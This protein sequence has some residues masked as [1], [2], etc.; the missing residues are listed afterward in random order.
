MN[1]Y[2]DSFIPVKEWFAPRQTDCVITSI[3]YDSD[4]FMRQNAEPNPFGSSDCLNVVEWLMIS[5]VPFL[6][7]GC[8]SLIFL[9]RFQSRT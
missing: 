9:L 1:A 3:T 6:A 8:G 2:L 7:F 5:T 4:G